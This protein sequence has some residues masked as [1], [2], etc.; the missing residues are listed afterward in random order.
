MIHKITFV[1][2]LLFT[3]IMAYSQ[4]VSDRGN[5]RSNT[6][7]DLNVGDT[8]PKHIMDYIGN[9][10][11]F[12]NEKIKL[13][14]KLIIL[15]FWGFNCMSCLEAFVEID[16]L[17]EQFS[18]Q[19]QIVL[20]NPQSASKTHK[21][22]DTRPRLLR[23]KAA[24]IYSDTLLD[25]IFSHTGV[26]Y[27]VWIDSSGIILHMTDGRH[28]TF[29]NIQKVLAGDTFKADNFKKTKKQQ[30]LFDSKEI[31]YIEYFSYLSLATY[32]RRITGTK[33]A[34]KS[35]IV[36]DPAKGVNLYQLAVFKD[37]AFRK[38]TEPWSFICEVSDDELKALNRGYAYHL[39]LPKE[40][41]ESK[42]A[43][44]H[45][46]LKRVFGLQGV[47]ELRTIKRIVLR[48]TT[49][50]DK[51]K[52]QGGNQSKGAFYRTSIKSERFDSVR[53]LSNY[54]FA[55]FS[56]ILGRMIQSEYG[57]PFY[58]ETGYSGNIDINVLGKAIDSL[59]ISALNNEFKKYDLELSEGTCHA[60][61]LVIK[62]LLK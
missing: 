10:K 15:D 18:K 9:A 40:Q 13:A 23:P 19:I 42:Y 6:P 37:S 35:E 2:I 49:N 4:N 60:R 45:D 1:T 61:V 29:Q 58:D 59:T 44:M 54:P 48:R 30:S 43:I 38:F 25:N 53:Y 47:I 55:S 62:P 22:F 16:S 26:P 11:T 46:D 52:T 57:I 36:I 8:V 7:I 5:L 56:N 12:K 41:S 14:G 21:F 28:L 17:Q 32:G 24:Y 39:L 31:P 50:I 27:H 34:S 51:L 3:V 33:K 20:V